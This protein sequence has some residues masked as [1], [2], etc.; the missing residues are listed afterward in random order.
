MDYN[1]ILEKEENILKVVIP[2]SIFNNNSTNEKQ[3]IKLVFINIITSDLEPIL[4]KIE[5]NRTP[6]KEERALVNNIIPYFFKK[7]GNVESYLV[8]FINLNIYQDIH[9]KHLRSIIFSELIKLKI[10]TEYD[11]NKNGLI[12]YSYKYNNDI[13]YYNSFINYLMQGNETITGKEIITLLRK[14]HI[15]SEREYGS[16][17]IQQILLRLELIA[18]VNYMSYEL[19]SRPKLLELFKNIPFIYS[20]IR[21]FYSIK[22]TYS[23]GN[24]FKIDVMSFEGYSSD[25]FL[26][27]EMHINNDDLNTSKLKMNLKRYLKY[28][29]TDNTVYN[30]R[31]GRILD[32]A[33]N[34]NINSRNNTIYCY[35]VSD[36]LEYKE[37]NLLKTDMGHMI[38]KNI[39]TI[40]IVNKS[41]NIVYYDKDEKIRRQYIDTPS[42]KIGDIYYNKLIYELFDIQLG[43]KLNLNILFQELVSTPDIPIIYLVSNGE[44]EYYNIYRTVIRDI[45]KQNI[46]LFIRKDDLILSMSEKILSSEPNFELR[47]LRYLKNLKYIKLKRHINEREYINIYLF[48]NGYVLSEINNEHVSYK[49]EELNMQINMINV[50]IKKIKNY[51]KLQELPVPNIEKTIRFT[52]G[53]MDYSSLIDMNLTINFDINPRICYLY[54]T[55]I[56]NKTLDWNTYKESKEIENTKIDAKKLIKTHL[57]NAINMNDNYL[58]ISNITD[59][60][61]ELSFIYRNQNYFYSDNNVRR[62]MLIESAGRKL[63]DNFKNKLLK[64]VQILFSITFEHAEKLFNDI[65]SNITQTTKTEINYIKCIINFDTNTITLKN[66]NNKFQYITILKDINQII[67]SIILSLNKNANDLTNKSYIIDKSRN[68]KQKS[69]IDSELI[70]SLDIDDDIFASIDIDDDIAALDDILK[71]EEQE[72]DKLKV[73]ETKNMDNNEKVKVNI[74]KKGKAISINKYMSQMREKFD[75]ALYNPIINGQQTDYKYGR[76]KCPNTKM[77][78]PFI[79]S[80][81]QLA[82]IDPESITGYMKYR[83]NYY[84]CPRIWDATVNKPIS[85]RKFINAGLKSPYTGSKPVLESKDKKRITSEHGVIIRKPVTDTQW[86][87]KGEYP[88]WP[89]ILKKTERDAFPGLTY[90]NDH[91]M[92]TC[93]PCCFINPPDD[94]EPESKELQEFK[95]PFGYQKC[96]MFEPDTLNEEDTTITI[97]DENEC[98]SEPYISGETSILKNCRLGL[99]PENINIFLNNNQRLF[100]N[101]NESGLINNSNLFLRRGIVKNQSQNILNTMTNVLGLPTVEYLINLIENKLSPLDFISLNNGELVSIFSDGSYNYAKEKQRLLDFISKFPKLLN[102]LNIDSDEITLL[103]ENIENIE[104]HTFSIK[105]IYNIYTSWRNYINYIKNNNEVK[106]I[107]YLIDLFVRPRDWLLKDGCNIIIFNKDG[108]N[109]NCLDIL[110]NKT[111]N[112]VMLIEEETNYYVPIALIKYKFNKL[113]PA[114]HL[115]E[116]NDSVNIEPKTFD[117]KKKIETN[118]VNNLIRLLYIQSNLCNYNLK[119]M[120]QK[121]LKIL[122]SKDFIITNQ[123]TDLTNRIGNIGFIEIINSMSNSKLE[124]TTN[125]I[126]P[127]FTNKYLYK[128]NILEYETLCQN[129]NKYNLTYTYYLNILTINDDNENDINN[130][131]LNEIMHLFD[132]IITTVYYETINSQDYITGI[133]F[134]N[135][136]SIP[137]KPEILTDKLKEKKID[138]ESVSLIKRFYPNILKTNIHSF[139]ITDITTQKKYIYNELNNV[140]NVIKNQLS[141]YISKRNTKYVDFI[142]NIRNG[143]VTYKQVNELL[144]N[145]IN[146]D[147]TL[148]ISNFLKLLIQ[149]DINKL[150][151]DVKGVEICVSQKLRIPTDIYKYIVYKIYKDI[152]NNKTEAYQIFKGK[153]IFSNNLNKDNIILSQNELVFILTNKLMSKYIKNYKYIN[154]YDVN[155]VEISDK[156]VNFLSSIIVDDITKFKTVTMITDSIASIKEV[157]V[158]REIYTTVFNSNGIYNPIAKVG[159][160]KFPYRSLNGNINYRCSDAK[161]VFRKPEL[162]KYNLEGKDQICPITVDN[163]KHIKTFGYCPEVLEESYNRLG[164]NPNIDTYEYNKEGQLEKSGKCIFPFIYYNKKTVNPLTGKKPFI[165]ISFTCQE[166][167]IDEGSWCYKRDE[168]ILPVYIGA[169]NRRHI[170]EG[171]WDM[172]QFMKND[173]ID[174]KNLKMVYEKSGYSKGICTT[175]LDKYREELIEK[176]LELSNVKQIKL[177]DYNPQFCILSESKKGYTKKQLYLFGKNILGLNYEVLINKNNKILNKSYLCNLFNT[178][179]SEINKERLNITDNKKKEKGYSSWYKLNIANCLNGPK[180]GGYK[181]NR[182]RNMVSTNMNIPFSK[183]N[184]MNKDTLCKLIKPDDKETIDYKTNEIY[185]SNKNINLCEKPVNRGGINKTKLNA[186]A[187]NLNIDIVGKKK[188]ELCRLIRNKMAV[189]KKKKENIKDYG[190]KSDITLTTLLKDELDELDT[191]LLSFTNNIED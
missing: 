141:V 95:K 48:E 30:E 174:Y 108:S 169:K 98:K 139:K 70:K 146:N 73:I 26:D 44:V 69:L 111:K 93:V 123:Y 62:F 22:Q 97:S 151:C 34:Y 29:Y 18:D 21:K 85:V 46:S 41:S 157:R 143:T 75:S 156:M 87:K 77:R 25:F 6:T 54:E 122:G 8:R 15:L 189:I 177:E 7:I 83:D 33:I 61:H 131:I 121:L 134:K 144:N 39:D 133:M 149:K 81:E 136:L 63:T 118:R 135:G 103:I 50:I 38:I 183:T 161:S 88:E 4:R 179:I 145:I 106:R 115:I 27:Y 64:N 181:L 80:K 36:I 99:L 67:K 137:V 90:S 86:E 162:V 68:T 164:I 129:I 72:Q 132:Y 167:K 51:F 182:L 180:K 147:A 3:D 57:G 190:L 11:A 55:L 79:V 12:L 53:E 148:E 24:I 158:K 56:N 188:P 130:I 178:K 159:V 125:I 173:N 114:I 150:I 28:N 172:S 176:Q 78:Q 107:E 92:K 102:Y 119:K 170:Y 2:R 40:D 74:I 112:L 163:K 66:I 126:L 153:Y 104:N 17:T 191:T 65:S 60:K 35:I 31:D 14:K 187:T 32:T 76:S 37:Y 124:K 100:L 154:N 13:K 155:T 9:L 45:S 96:S 84:I 168:N 171:K 59:G 185:P 128:I 166:G 42:I 89:S 152:C 1:K 10:I 47:K 58:L 120:T 91:P 82:D 109:M 110:N 117:S 165:Q 116:I 19:L 113:L 71:M 5:E 138:G 127:I 140:I 101:S 49:F 184:N 186:I 52:S 23:S 43:Y 175:K 160:C 16:M 142:S 105:I 94:Y 20:P